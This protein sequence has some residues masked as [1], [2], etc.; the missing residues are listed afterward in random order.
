MAGL[1][2]E[3]LK[4]SQDSW[5]WGAF[6]EGLAEDLED[7]IEKVQQGRKNG[8][9]IGSEYFAAA[10]F[11]EAMDELTAFANDAEEII[12][13]RLGAGVND[14][15]QLKEAIERIKKEVIAA[16]PQIK[17]EVKKWFDVEVDRMMAER[18]GGVYN[19]LS[20]IQS[21][22]IEHIKHDSGAALRR[23]SDDILDTS[24]ELDDEVLS[25]ISKAWG[26]LKD[27][28]PAESQDLISKLQKQMDENPLTLR[29]LLLQAGEQQIRDDIQKDYEEHFYD[30]NIGEKPTRPKDVGSLWGDYKGDFA[31]FAAAQ[32]KHEKE[33]V[34][35]NQ[36]NAEWEAKRAEYVAKYGDFNKKNDETRAKWAKRVND[37]IEA[38]DAEEKAAKHARQAL[39][40]ELSLEERKTDARYLS[41]VQEEQAAKDRKSAAQEVWN[42]ENEEASQSLF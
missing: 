4:V 17:G 41:A 5:L 20:S 35:Y 40:S 25:A 18:F 28:L 37:E 36:K 22:F 24:K 29:V 34:E 9:N 13:D 1:N 19:E 33:M 7:Y 14:A 31:K 21:Q 16:N 39:E 2:A 30:S 3:A 6:G 26:K 10:E 23:L 8:A 15:V 27:E 12:R 32:K 38:A 11:N 42:Y